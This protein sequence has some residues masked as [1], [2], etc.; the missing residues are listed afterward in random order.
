MSFVLSEAFIIGNHK[1]ELSNNILFCLQLYLN[2]NYD[3]INTLEIPWEI[4]E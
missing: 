2:M 3:G 1:L 4:L